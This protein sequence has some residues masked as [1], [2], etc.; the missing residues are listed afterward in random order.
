MQIGGH[1]IQS[2]ALSLI[3]N[4]VFGLDC[5]TYL[6]YFCLCRSL[7]G[8]G[9]FNWRFV[10]PFQFIPAEK[11]LVLEEK[12]LAFSLFARPLRVKIRST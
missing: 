6:L 12:V 9:N 1:Q 4:W 2:H 8:E 3:C 5:F 10:F 7:N 11:K